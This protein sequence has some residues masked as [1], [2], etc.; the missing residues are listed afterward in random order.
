MPFGEG[1]EGFEQ[2][3]SSGQE[4]NLVADREEDVSSETDDLARALDKAIDGEPVEFVNDKPVFKESEQS[5]KEKPS[6]ETKSGDNIKESTPQKDESRQEA[7]PESK[8]KASSKQTRKAEPPLFWDREAK[9]LFNSAPL[10]DPRALEDWVEKAKQQLVKQ[11][12]LRNSDHTRKSQE[13]AEK[14]RRYEGLEQVVEPHRQ[15]LMARGMQPEVFFAQALDLDKRLREDPK[16][17]LLDLAQKLNVNLSGSAGA[18]GQNNSSGQSTQ[19]TQGSYTPTYKDPRVDV[20]EQ[21]LAQA[22]Q[23]AFQSRAEKWNNAEKEFRAQADEKFPYLEEIED[24]MIPVITQLVKA[25]PDIDPMD[26][27][28]K[29]Y[30]L[31]C[32]NHPELRQRLIDQ[33]IEQRQQQSQSDLRRHQSAAHSLSS[34]ELAGTQSVEVPDD[35]EETMRMVLEGKLK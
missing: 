22:E 19:A 17:A 6:I 13:I 34:G 3:E 31:V 18:G 29:A 32:W 15:S 16:A 33:Q 7:K 30:D 35:V 14:R 11:E 12:K 24:Q 1:S 21:R 25:S 9:E 20:L 28:S 5:G 23:T 27:Y 2:E 8:P 4:V 10:N 26:C